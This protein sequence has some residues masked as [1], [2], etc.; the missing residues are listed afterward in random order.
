MFSR[1]MRVELSTGPGAKSPESGLSRPIFSGPDDCAD[2]VNS[3]EA[4]QNAY[5]FQAEAEHFDAGGIRE[6]EHNSNPGSE[7]FT[8]PSA[9]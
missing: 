4:S 8:P 7:W 2:L 3:W 6:K 1:V 9:E 5:L